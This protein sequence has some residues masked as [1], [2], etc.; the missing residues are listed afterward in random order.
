MHIEMHAPLAATIN[1]TLGVRSNMP[2][3][4]IDG[5]KLGGNYVRVTLNDI[6]T[7]AGRI[8]R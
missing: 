5:V 8:Q 7:S 6:I 2:H 3:Q 4:R 1:S